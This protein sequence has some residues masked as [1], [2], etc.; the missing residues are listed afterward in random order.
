MDSS[1]PV[2]FKVRRIIGSALIDFGK[3]SSDIASRLWQSEPVSPGATALLDGKL[4]RDSALTDVSTALAAGTDQ[5]HAFARLI[6]MPEEF[7]PS[8]AVVARGCIETLGR[9]WWLLD[10]ESALQMEAR[11]LAMSEKEMEVSKAKGVEIGRV[12][13][14]GGREDLD[15][16]EV[17]AE[18]R[19]KIAAL[20]VTE[21]VPGYTALASAVMLAA[22]VEHPEREYSHL[23]GAAHGEFTTVSSL[24]N[25]ST[26][27]SG[28]P[29]VKL[30]LPI[31]HMHMYC[32]TVT[33]VLDV[34]MCRLI[35]LWGIRAEGE[36]LDA[37]RRRT[38]EDF[39]A[40]G[41]LLKDA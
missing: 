35:D 31:S 28:A 39:D 37:A 18:L 2:P 14:D 27:A 33:H 15:I 9:G 5:F 16:D 23:S 6:R 12:K 24:G 40:L 38:Y 4:L 22:G 20:G 7:G 11:A 36:R 13:T 25:V 26:D 32:W 34:V 19:A 30:G 41:Q 10:S 1:L 3:T 29:V 21:R 8:I 17:L